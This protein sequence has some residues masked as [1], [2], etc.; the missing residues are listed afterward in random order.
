MSVVPVVDG[1]AGAEASIEP[2]TKL[3]GRVQRV[4]KFGVLVWLRPGRVGLIPSVHTG[5]RRGTDLTRSFPVAQEIEVEVLEA[6][7]DGRRIRL[8]VP[9]LPSAP[10]R[11]RGRAHHRSEAS[12]ALAAETRTG[13]RAASGA[14]LRHEPGRRAAQAIHKRAATPRPDAG[15][16]RAVG[17]IPPRSRV[18]GAPFAGRLR[19]QPM[20]EAQVTKRRSG[21]PY[22]AVALASGDGR[23]P[24]TASRTTASCSARCRRLEPVAGLALR[25]RPT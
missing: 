16:S 4:E 20:R 5:T 10:R 11:R 3:K 24:I 6:D 2:G 13:S 1:D 7:P 25:R 14:D 9:A 21:D 18:R 22:S 15:H 23:S 8:A 17:G 12:R 19:G